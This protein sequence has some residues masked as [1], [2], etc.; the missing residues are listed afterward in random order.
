MLTISSDGIKIL[1]YVL[2]KHLHM[3]I[4][5]CKY[6]TRTHKVFLWEKSSTYILKNT[7]AFSFFF[8]PFLVANEENPHLSFIWIRFHGCLLQNILLSQK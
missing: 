2:Q 8:F 4:P 7:P 1:I 6:F 5:M 3:V